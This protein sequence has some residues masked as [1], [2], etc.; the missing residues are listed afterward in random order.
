MNRIQPNPLTPRSQLSYL[1]R[2]FVSVLCRN[3]GRASWRSLVFSRSTH[4]MAPRA[5]LRQSSLLASSPGPCLRA[6]ETSHACI[7]GCFSHIRLFAT[8]WTV[9]HQALLSMGFSRQEHQSGLPFPPPGIFPTQGSNSNLF[10][11]LHWQAGSLPPPGKPNIH[12]Q[13]PIVSSLR[14]PTLN[15]PSSQFTQHIFTRSLLCVTSIGFQNQVTGYSETVQALFSPNP[16]VLGKKWCM[17]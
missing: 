12:F 16:I 10:C 2:S 9:A 13:C 3:L 1:T 6:I 5:T 17:D 7:L 4:K 8:P 15:L 14:L 11:L